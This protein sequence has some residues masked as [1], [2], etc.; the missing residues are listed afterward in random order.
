MTYQPAN[1]SDKIP[2]F[3]KN[4]KIEYLFI[5]GLNLYF[6]CFSN[7]LDYLNNGLFE[8]NIS[9]SVKKYMKNFLRA[10][11]KGKCK[12]LYELIFSSYDYNMIRNIILMNENFKLYNIRYNFFCKNN[13][14]DEYD[15]KDN[16]YFVDGKPYPG[17]KEFYD[18]FKKVFDQINY[19]SNRYNYPDCDCD[20][21]FDFDF[22][23]DC[24]CDCDCDSDSDY[25]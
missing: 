1:K 24:D 18:I 22:D 13:I 9:K 2:L 7:K 16:E 23:C 10:Q 21:D 19:E 11:E 12:N 25:L 5:R 8:M 17:F 6:K 4:H 14:Y 15:D 20:C 3:A